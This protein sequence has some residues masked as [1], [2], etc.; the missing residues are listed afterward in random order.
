[1]HLVG[2]TIGFVSVLVL[3]FGLGIIRRQC[4]L[5]EIAGLRVDV[6]DALS[7]L[8]FYAA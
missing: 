2:C 1:V 8:S 3:G 4:D 5:R 6:D 7:L